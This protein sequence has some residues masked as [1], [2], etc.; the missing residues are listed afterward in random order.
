MRIYMLYVHIY[1]YIYIYI[2]THIYIDMSAFKI[3]LT[4]TLLPAL[5]VNTERGGVF[6]ML[7]Y[8]TRLHFASSALVHTHM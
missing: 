2:H 3:Q 7:T 6:S 5:L 1:I 4:Y 8:R